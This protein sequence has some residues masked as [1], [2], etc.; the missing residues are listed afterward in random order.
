L[1]SVSRMNGILENRLH[2]FRVGHEIRRE[3]SAVE[4]HALDHVEHGLGGFCLLDRYHAL[5]ADLLHGL[6]DQL[7]DHRIVVRGDGRDLLLLAERL[8]RPR[9][10]ARAATRPRPSRPGRARASGRWRWCRQRHCFRPSAN[11]ACARIVEV[12]V[13]S[14]TMPRRSSR[15][16]G[17][18]CA[19]R[20]FPPD[21]ED[22][23]SFAMV[24][25]SL[26]TIGLPQLF[27]IR[28]DLD[29]GPSVT[30]T[31]SASAVAPL[32][33]FS[34]A[35]ERK[36]ICLWATTPSPLRKSQ[37]LLVSLPSSGNF[38]L[39]PV[40]KCLYADKKAEH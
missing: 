17:A 29:F 40:N 11:I 28:T 5:G 27:W 12:L 24:T 23:T 32:R 6:R 31:A 25:P 9:Q 34:R 13:P 10:T 33:I 8:H 20:G 14:P 15:Q 16:P 36:R 22:R 1:R 18:A 30:R 39:L 3:V 4:L 19:R 35:A 7:A 26:Q 21:P 38:E 37:W 2:L